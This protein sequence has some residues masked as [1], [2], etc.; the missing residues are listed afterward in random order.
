MYN[1]Y[2]HKR[3][4][5]NLLKDL[6]ICLSHMLIWLLTNKNVIFI[7]EAVQHTCI[8][9]IHRS[10]ANIYIPAILFFFNKCEV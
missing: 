5:L 2:I 9:S 6:P 10:H 3:S 1:I 8:S 7:S 4:K